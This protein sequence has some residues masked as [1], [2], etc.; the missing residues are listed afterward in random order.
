LEFR[1]SAIDGAGLEVVCGLPNVKHLD[2]AE[3]K[4]PSPE[5]LAK[6]GQLTG[7]TYLGLTE[8]KLDD[9]AFGA[10][11]GLVELRQLDA[12]GTSIGDD[13]LD[14]LLGMEEL[15]SLDVSGTYLTDDSF[16][17]IGKLPNLKS[18]KAANTE[19][20]YEV[21]DELAESRPDLEV[22]DY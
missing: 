17:E 20:G 12:S 1:D 8:T 14:V 9:E 3:C 22:L 13:S 6:I 2:L 4:L 11:D 15:Q 19:I 10:M 16:R 21:I 7:L 5:G 18:L